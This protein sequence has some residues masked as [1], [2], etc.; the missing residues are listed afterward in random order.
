MTELDDRAIAHLAGLGHEV[1]DELKSV[2]G[3]LEHGGDAAREAKRLNWGATGQPYDGVNLGESASG[4]VIVNDGATDAYI[5]ESSERLNQAGALFTVPAGTWL[6][7]PYRAARLVLGGASATTVGTAWLLVMADAPTFAM[8][9][10]SGH[11]Y[12]KGKTHN[13]VSIPAGQSVGVD[14]VT[15]GYSV[16]RLLIRMTATAAGDLVPGVSP[17]EDDGTTLNQ[18]PTLVGTGNAVVLAGGVD[19]QT[20]WYTL[21]GVDKVNVRIGNANA[22]AQTAT[23]VYFLQK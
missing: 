9:S 6:A 10:L 4:F 15:A 2:R 12:A 7:I 3:L 8:G 21:A 19:Y 5:A 1:L 16:L 22:A 20:L 23:C 13:A 18:P 11:P 17:Y 14:L